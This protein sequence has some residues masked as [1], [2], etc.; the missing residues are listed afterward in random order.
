MKKLIALMGLGIGLIASY[1]NGCAT[2]DT[3]Y[4]KQ[5]DTKKIEQV[6]TKENQGVSVKPKIRS[7]D[8]VA[9]EYFPDIPGDPNSDIENYGIGVFCA[10]DLTAA[11]PRAENW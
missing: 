6:V 10:D 2:L 9:K 11:M 4:S 3:K 5:V 8:D 7:I 1:I